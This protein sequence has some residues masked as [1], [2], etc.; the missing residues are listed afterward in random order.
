MAGI[1]AIFT[2]LWHYRRYGVEAYDRALD[3]A[4]S[5]NKV[6]DVASQIRQLVESK[7]S[8]SMPFVRQSLQARIRVH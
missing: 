7:E 1:S 3:A 8:A 4:L 2:P 5:L 6:D